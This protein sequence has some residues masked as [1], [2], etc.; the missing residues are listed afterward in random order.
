MLVENGGAIEVPVVGAGEAISEG[1]TIVSV[2]GEGGEE[3]SE[4]L[5]KR[6]GNAKGAER[7]VSV[8][9]GGVGVDVRTA[10]VPVSVGVV[11]GPKVH[12]E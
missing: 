3:E 7:D 8:D 10:S 2:D 5:R 12:E 11:Q 4:G 6:T 9:V 1:E